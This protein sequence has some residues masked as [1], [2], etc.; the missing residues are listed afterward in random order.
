MIT[1]R[2]KVPSQNS[3]LIYSSSSNRRGIS[4]KLSPNIAATEFRLLMNR[5]IVTV[6]GFPR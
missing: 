3:K 6:M 4:I 5:K 2:H 1:G